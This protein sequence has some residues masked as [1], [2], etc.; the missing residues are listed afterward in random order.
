MKIDKPEKARRGTVSLLP[1]P[2]PAQEDEAF[3]ELSREG[4]LALA[5]AVVKSSAAR[6]RRF[7]IPG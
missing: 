6:A 5:V 7:S 1:S 2:P 3:G 4:E